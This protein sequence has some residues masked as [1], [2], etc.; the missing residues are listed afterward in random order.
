MKMN[1]LTLSVILAVNVI[2]GGACFW[3][4]KSQ[5]EA[6]KVPDR[7]T[8]GTSLTLANAMGTESKS[9][10]SALPGVSSIDQK[11]SRS[12]SMKSSSG[13]GGMRQRLR[14]LADRIETMD[15]KQVLASLKKLRPQP[16]SPDKLMAEQ[17]L[18]ARYGELDPETA[19]TYVETLAGV[20]YETS[21]LTVMSAWTGSDP[22]AAAAHYSE[23]LD[24]FGIRD[25]HQ[26]VTAGTVAAEWARQDPEAAL[27]WADDLPVEVRGEAYG[28]IAAQIVTEDPTRATAILDSMEPGLER[29]EMMGNLVSQWAYQ[30]PQ[31]AA[32]WVVNNTTGSE[33]SQGASSLMTAWMVANPLEAST[34][35]GSLD[36]GATRDSAIVALTQSRAVSSDPV[37]AIAWSESIQDPN[38]R[39]DA[40][41]QAADQWLNADP[42][43]A[44]AWLQSQAS[45]STAR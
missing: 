23:N 39:N 18:L 8:T 26:R 37:A 25:D 15:V 24:D 31:A 35:L 9:P 33:Q 22:E 44:Q 42:A 21:G 2:V 27:T 32:D 16:G 34:W 45:S 10:D 43:A 29:T 38:L 19:L 12:L 6:P 20:E 40:I 11:S 17:M 3:F 30:D 36:D 4:G 28:R 5:G 41:K 1:R 13:G 7:S 14:E